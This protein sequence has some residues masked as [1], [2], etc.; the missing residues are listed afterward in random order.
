MKQQPRAE[1]L[2]AP[3]R[4]VAER[5]AYWR[6]MSWEELVEQMEC[7]TEDGAAPAAGL[8]APRVEVLLRRD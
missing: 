5:L 2:Q 4:A 7:T 1:A 3:G 8:Q 6:S